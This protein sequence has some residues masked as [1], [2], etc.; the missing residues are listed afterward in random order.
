MRNP[1]KSSTEDNTE[2][3]STS[4]RPTSP[5]GTGSQCAS[6]SGDCLTIVKSGPL[7]PETHLLKSKKEF[8]VL[9]TSA[10]IKFKNRS[11]AV[12]RFPQ[13]TGSSSTIDLLSAADSTSSLR[14]LGTG[15]ELNIPL[16][17]IVSVFNNE[18]TRPSFGIEVWWSDSRGAVFTCIQ[19]DFGLPED[20]DEWLK[21]IR[22]TIKLR[23]KSF[24]EDS[25]PSSVELQLK[26]ILEAQQAQHR[27]AQIEIFPVVPRRPYARP[28]ANSGEVKKGW[29]D[30]SSF[31][32]AFTKYFCVLAQFTK[33]SAGQKVNPDLTRFGLVALSKVNVI[34]NDERF[35]LVFRL[36]LEKP[37]KLEL[38]S[39]HHRTISSKLYKA[40]L[41]LKPAWP[42]WTRREV[43]FIDGETPQMPLP[44]GE[45][46]GGFKTTL[47]A[48]LGAYGCAPVDW[49][50][51]WKNVRHPPQFCLLAPKEKTQY[52]S[53][54]L[55]AVFRALRFN[56]Y[57]KSL[58]FHDIDFSSLVG[59]TDNISRIESTIWLSRTGKRSLTRVE[60]ELVENSPVLFQEIVALLLG[61]E[62]IR[63]IDLTSVLSKPPKSSPENGQAFPFPSGPVC[64]VVPPVLLLWKSLQTR[65]N[66][67]NLSGN[68][69][70][71]SDIASLS[72]V[73]Q[74]RP[75]F[76]KTFSASRCQ[77]DESALVLLWEGLHEQRSIIE[78]L[79]VSHNSGRIE[80]G[81]ASEILKDA[82]KLRHLNLAYSIKGSLNGPLFR[83]WSATSNFEPW[84]L[85]ELDLSG[86]QI[87][88]DT[89][90]G[91]M[92]FLELD[93]SRSLRRLVLTNCGLS[94]EM[95]TGLLC[96]LGGG[97]DMH[98]LLSMNP[99]ELGSTD[100]IDLIHGNEA[101]KML[102]LDMIEFQRESNFHRLL[103][104]L[105][106][107]K[108]IEFL[109]MVG[110]GPPDRASANTSELLSC[111]FEQNNT[112]RYLDLSGYDGKLE[113][114]H[115]GWGLAGALGGLK[116]NT[117]LR[118]FRV[119]NHDLGAAEDVSEL[120]R[121]LAANKGLAM[122]DCQQNSLN[123]HQFAKLVHALSFNNQILSFPMSDA[124]RQYAVQK[125]R[126]M[127]LQQQ[128]QPAK[129]LP[130]KM[131]KSAEGRL[132]GLLKWVE[133]FWNTEAAKAREILERNRI[134]LAN[135]SLAFESEYLEAWDDDSLPSWLLA[136]LSARDKGKETL[137][138]RQISETTL[139][140]R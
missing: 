88:F 128:A 81:K 80:A 56:D 95:A 134:N 33:A 51:Q 125:E 117:T 114:G 121:V 72:R 23:A 13:I 90:C 50:V 137:H 17:K 84:R 115:L 126:R 54:Q 38:S 79:D 139:P 112:L 8:L 22:H 92:K 64:E 16:G 111:F 43:F 28:K 73:L 30:N 103:K 109:S 130:A 34:L 104:A 25:I 119:R 39:R 32:V 102:H 10:L 124:D 106:D 21:H 31:Y 99:L 12:D 6:I 62:S 123:H 105:A 2:R 27:D 3:A 135:H 60:F 132:D 71:I 78:S 116:H 61:S 24:P 138:K 59:T 53:H 20:R 133:E 77:L 120:C 26:Q 100:W 136:T 89:L 87:N 118:Q 46:Y 97:R 11:A 57:F 107:N 9:T 91:I 58:S 7:Q 35:D 85:E 69:L 129:S 1:S 76:L 52:T 75:D 93:E 14:D 82:S 94:G 70:G 5:S 74:N 86:W 40:D 127:F 41:Y 15:G 67:I 49:M 29:R 98:L 113:D 36:P 65:C 122:F 83:P 42:L 108:T 19:L 47:E 131:L 55:L 4:T 110:T 48:F 63:H 18:G 68:P 37:Q 44:N 45:D 101:P 140:Y 66:S 96:R